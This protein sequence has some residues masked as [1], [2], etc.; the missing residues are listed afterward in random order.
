M[1]KNHLQAMRK[2]LNW[3]TTFINRENTN[4][5]I[6]QEINKRITET[7]K[8]N[9]KTRKDQNKK[10]KQVKKVSSF[11]EFYKIMKLK[12]IEKTINSKDE[13]HKITFDNQLRPRIPPAR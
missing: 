13:I 7:T 5:K 2:L 10:A 12:R 3:D 9:N 6:Y 1:E 11:T 8:E 4:E